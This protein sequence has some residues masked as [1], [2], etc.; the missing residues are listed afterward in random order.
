[1]CGILAVLL[2]DHTDNCRTIL[3]DGLTILQHRGQDAAGIVT[4]S[5][6]KYVKFHIQKGVGMVKDVFRKNILLGLIGNIGIGHCR[7]PTA[8]CHDFQSA[9]PFYINYPCGLS[10]AHN[11]TLTSTSELK[12]RLRKLYRHF[13]TDSD[14]EVLLNCVAEEIRA[15]L[16][17]RRAEKSTAS[18]DVDVIFSAVKRTMEHCRGGYACVMLIHNVGVVAFRDPWGIRP[19]CYGQRKSLTLELGMDYLFASESVAIDTMGFDLL[20]DVAPG[21]CIVTLPMKPGH[22]RPNS[23]LF[24]KQLLTKTFAPCVFE[25]VYFARPDSVMNGCSVYKTRLNM[26]EK[27]ADKISRVHPNHKID[28]VIPIPDTSRASA[29]QC[30]LK[31][32]KPFREG[33]I[34]NRYVGRTFIMPDQASRIKGVRMKLNTIKTEFQGKNVLL[35]DDSIVRGNTSRTLCAMAREAGAE[36]VYLASAAPPVLYPNVYGIDIPAAKGLIAHNRTTKQIAEKIGCTW[37]LY[38]DLV[39]L[40]ECV[41]AENSNI[42][43]LESSVFSG[44]YVTDDVDTSFFHALEAGRPDPEEKDIKQDNN[45]KRK[46]NE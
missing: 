18:I 29:L 44:K 35:I 41:R 20:G 3:F 4:A 37:V 2:A 31:L 32:K 38:Q 1:M 26:G 16:D 43:L 9:Q 14:S 17:T 8:G 46:I 13:N 21:E 45:K 5:T 12:Q 15:E 24:K 25:Y 19:L 42:K 22:P 34:K 28:V 27:L 36:E 10:L 33:F 40:E 39:D 23:G 11:G 30:A 7:Y 6:V